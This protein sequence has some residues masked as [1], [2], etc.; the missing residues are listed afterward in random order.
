MQA[1]RWKITTVLFILTEVIFAQNKELI[2]SSITDVIVYRQGAQ[3]TRKGNFLSKTGVSTLVIQNV[4][5]YVDPN[6]IQVKLTGNVVVLDTKFGQEYPEPTTKSLEGLPLS[7]QKS[8]AQVEDS[9]T[10]LTYQLEDLKDE[11]SVLRSS[12]SILDKNGAVQ[13]NGKVNDSIQLLK[14]VVDYYQLKMNEL[15]KK[16]AQVNRSLKQKQE[17]LTGMQKR[18]QN[19]KNYQQSNVP[20]EPDGP[21]YQIT[22]TIQGKETV[23]GKISVNYVVSNAGWEPSYDLNCDVLTGKMN[24]NY[25]AFVHQ[26]TEEEWKDVKLTISTNDPYQNKTKPDLSPNYLN[27]VYNQLREK[28]ARSDIQRAPRIEQKQV[29]SM[30]KDED[31]LLDSNDNESFEVQANQSFEWTTVSDLTVAA[32]FKIDLVY[33]IKSDDENH[34]VLI[35]NNDLAVNY[36]Y[37]TVPKVESGVFLVG[38]IQKLDELQLVP[39]NATIIFDGSYIGQTYLNPS[40][41]QDT[42]LLSLGKDPNIIIKRTLL[43]KENK[44]KIVGNTKEKIFS[45]EIE[46]KNLKSTSIELNIEDQL[47][48]SQIGEIIV[49]PLDLEKAEYDETT[50]KLVWRKKLKTKESEKIKFSYKVKYP[51]DKQIQF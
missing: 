34:I 1:M 8:I 37:Y 20:I 41:L 24:L 17:Q 9:I 39:A 26:Q 4:S 19:L 15:N 32:E 18:L 42:L 36:T 50:G 45:F 46:V 22:I 40:T 43:K 6:S 5:P 2:T 31:G 11:I 16:M 49:E 35:Q 27:F 23:N 3:I 48:I 21:M 7:I 28:M 10:N 25:K 29:A 47:P 14:Q 51:K 30:E 12:K 44:E 38:E 33:T 13:G